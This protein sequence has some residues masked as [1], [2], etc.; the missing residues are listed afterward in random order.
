MRLTI[1]DNGRGVTQALID[2]VRTALTSRIPAEFTSGLTNIH[3]RLTLLGKGGGLDV[4]RSPLGGFRVII[5][6][7]KEN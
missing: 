5:S 7:P 3:H 2:S 6:I 1:D 4:D